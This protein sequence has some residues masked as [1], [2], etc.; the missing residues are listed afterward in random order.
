MEIRALNVA[1]EIRVAVD[2][3]HRWD[4]RSVANAMLFDSCFVFDK[5]TKSM[6]KRG[7][8]YII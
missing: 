5:G 7:I 3:I 1:D 4:C 6:R 2:A 8:T